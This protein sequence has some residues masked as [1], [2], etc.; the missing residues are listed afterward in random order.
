MTTP[1]NI[2]WLAAGVL[3]VIASIAIN[4]QVKIAM[5]RQRTG[6]LREMGN[7]KVG[8]PAPDFT[9][10]DLSNQPVSLSSLRGKKVVLL[11]FWATWCGPCR[12]AMPGLQELQDKFKSKGF[13]VLSVDQAEGSDVVRPFIERKKYS[14][15]VVLDADGQV[16]SQYGV[17]GIPTLVLVDKK[18][19]V[20]FIRV[21]YSPNEEDLNAMV[22]HLV[23]ELP[24]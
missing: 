21:G 10:N 22:E 6:S 13:E 3:F 2:A 17:R 11:D 14:F 24:P 16:G 7:V 15:H 20:Q 18:G 9:L 1:R 4:Y 23:A 19:G 5:H 12:M 8:Q